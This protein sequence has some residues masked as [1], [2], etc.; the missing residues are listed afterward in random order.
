VGEP[1]DDH[2]ALRA[3]LAKQRERLRPTIEAGQ[4]LDRQVLPTPEAPRGRLS[5]VPASGVV[6]GASLEAG[7][8]AVARDVVASLGSTVTA[9]SK[10]SLHAR[11]ASSMRRRRRSIGNSISRTTAAHHAANAEL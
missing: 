5:H 4:E 11:S 7:K 8:L 6:L 10:R 2:R 9:I 3:L 1:Q